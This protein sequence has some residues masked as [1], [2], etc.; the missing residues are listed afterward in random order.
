M[1]IALTL[2]G[3][4]GDEKLLEKDSSDSERLRLRYMVRDCKVGGDERL[5]RPV[6]NRGCR[7]CL[8]NTIITGFAPSFRDTLETRRHTDV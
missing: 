2:S 1:S 3:R 8:R 5:K 7:I 4:G 6:C